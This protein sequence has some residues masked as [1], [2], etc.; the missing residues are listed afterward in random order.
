MNH[1][2]KCFNESN[3]SRPHS[4][5]RLVDYLVASTFHRMVVKAVAH[6]LT[7]L[8]QRLCQTPIQSWSQPDP[9]DEEV[10]RSGGQNNGTSPRTVQKS[11]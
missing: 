2:D 8:Q 5:I 4:F 11:I 6:V 1:C 7:V 9:T 3:T 10:N